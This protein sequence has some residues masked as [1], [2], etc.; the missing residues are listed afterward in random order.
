M[1]FIAAPFPRT[2]NFLLESIAHN[3][4]NQFQE[5]KNLV[6]VVSSILNAVSTLY[7]T[8]I[9]TLFHFAKN[10]GFFHPFCRDSI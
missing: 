3:Q 6:L 1:T 5:E 2:I 9:P 8:E 7:R 10:M 4:G